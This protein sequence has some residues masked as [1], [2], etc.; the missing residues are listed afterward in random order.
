MESRI[1]AATRMFDG[2]TGWLGRCLGPQV[3]ETRYNCWDDICLLPCG[4][5][6]EI[7]SVS[8]LDEAGELQT[9]TSDYWTLDDDHLYFATGWTGPTT[10]DRSY[11]IRVRYTAGYSGEDVYDGGTGQV[12]PEAIEAIIAMTKDMLASRATDSDVRSETVEDVGAITYRDADKVSAS[13]LA[14]AQR[15]VSGLRVMF[16]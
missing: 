3:L 12:P 13:V 6:V 2:P 1:A 4:P 11:A 9:V 8:Y 5:V 10:A 14:E 16:V 7:E 15:L